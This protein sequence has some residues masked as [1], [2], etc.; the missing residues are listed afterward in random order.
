MASDRPPSRSVP[1]AVSTLSADMVGGPAVPA[2]VVGVHRFALYLDVGGCVLPVLTSDAVPLPT[3]LR[4]AEPSGSVPWGVVAGDEV[5]VGEGRVA[6]PG[7]DVVAARTWRPARVRPAAAAVGCP[8]GRR[9]SHLS[10]QLELRG[11]S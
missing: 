7:L 1:A 6:L 4:L 11:S 8:G 2:R 9:G 3:A 10:T 5:L